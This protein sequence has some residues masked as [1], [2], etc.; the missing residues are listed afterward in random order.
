MLALLED[1]TEKKRETREQKQPEQHKQH[2][3]PNHHTMK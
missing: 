1:N 3:V 2:T